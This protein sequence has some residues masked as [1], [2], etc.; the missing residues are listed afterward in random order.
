MKGFLF[1]ILILAS[2]YWCYDNYGKNL[3]VQSTLSH[4]DGRSMDVVILSRGKTQVDFKRK[5][6]GQHFSC[7][8][9]DL[10]LL[11]KCKV[12][13][14]FSDSS[15]SSSVSPTLGGSVVGDLHLKGMRDEM[16]DLA[17]KLDFAEYQL[18]AAGSNAKRRTIENEIETLELQMNQLEL[19]QADYLRH[20]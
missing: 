4:L 13:W 12:Y 7:G 15:S 16:K 3:P 11:S 1:F 10:S 20:R 9:R 19:K 14:Y 18:G 5:S 2:G 6:D 17:G 8:I